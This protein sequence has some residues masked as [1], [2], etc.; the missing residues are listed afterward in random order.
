MNKPYF[1]V[2]NKFRRRSIYIYETWNPIYS[3]RSLLTFYSAV[4]ENLRNLWK[5]Q[6]WQWVIYHEG[7]FSFECL[8]VS[9]EIFPFI[10]VMEHANEK[11]KS[12]YN[13]Y[14]PP[15]GLN[16]LRKWGTFRFSLPFH[17]RKL[18]SST[19]E[20]MSRANCECT[21]TSSEFS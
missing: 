13:F 15:P 1:K 14:F 3:R 18:L 4:T 6:Q 17:L 9:I 19:Y 8:I 2:S 5:I 10:Y 21:T 11:K 7:H 12:R 20:L 16:Y